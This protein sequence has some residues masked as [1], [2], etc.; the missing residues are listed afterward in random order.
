MV[1]AAI[2]ASRAAGAPAEPKPAEAALQTVRVAPQ[3]DASPSPRRDQN[4]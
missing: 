1:D 2:A 3:V 4:S